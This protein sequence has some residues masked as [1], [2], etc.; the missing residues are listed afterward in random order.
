MSTYDKLNPEI[1][2]DPEFSKALERAKEKILTEKKEKEEDLDELTGAYQAGKTTGLYNYITE[3]DNKSLFFFCSIF[4]VV[5]SIVN[6]LYFTTSSIVAII[7]AT[8]VVYFLNEKRRTTEFS[9]MTELEIKLVRIT[10]NPKYFHLDAGIVE[11]VYSIREFRNYNDEAFVEMIISIDKF[12]AMVY[13]VEN[14][15]ANCHH[16]IELAQSF[17]KQALNHLM[18]IIYR[19][20]QSDLIY[21]K[22][23]TAA[24]SLHFILNHHIKTMKDQCNK[25]IKEE[26][27][28]S[29]NSL[30]I[31][32][33]PLGF[34][35]NFKNN[36]D[37]F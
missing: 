5:F 27:L 33:H 11:L 14:D 6:K 18:S 29:M 37:L 12:L 13:D 1:N 20:P 4:L 8:I 3:I 24:N 9:D 7:A 2:N 22:L 30:V 31:T 35:E 15:V 23:R 26:G 25:K 28:N 10:P 19:A 34:D 21:K 17:K 32:N 36:F 16:S